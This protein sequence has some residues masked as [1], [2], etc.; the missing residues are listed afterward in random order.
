[1]KSQQSRPWG[2]SKSAVGHIYKY[3]LNIKHA[4]RS[5]TYLLLVSGGLEL[6]GLLRELRVSL[7]DASLSMSEKSNKCVCGGDMIILAIQI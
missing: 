5:L 2:K 7:R 3:S 4:I 6:L 1:M